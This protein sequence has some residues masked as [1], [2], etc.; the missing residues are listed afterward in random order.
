[1]WNYTN[2]AK[3]TPAWSKEHCEAAQREGWD[4]FD[5]QG[6]DCGPWQIQRFDDA[7]DVPGAPQ[8]KDDN[9]AWLIVVEGTGAHHA[10]ARDFI[11]A[12]NQQEWAALMSNYIEQ[13]ANVAEENQR[14]QEGAR[15]GNNCVTMNP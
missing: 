12:H 10:A 5:A 14:I 13:T 4:I 7:P 6:S 8:L 11:K 9:A 3:M 1:M 15:M 2:P